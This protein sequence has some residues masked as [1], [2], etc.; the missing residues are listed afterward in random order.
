M[1]ASEAARRE[2][3]WDGGIEEGWGREEVGPTRGTFARGSLPRG[4]FV[5]LCGCTVV[6]RLSALG[7]RLQ[8]RDRNIADLQVWQSL[9]Q[10]RNSF[11]RSPSLERFLEIDGTHGLLVQITLGVGC[12]FVVAR[13]CWSPTARLHKA[14]RHLLRKTNSRNRFEKGCVVFQGTV[15]TV[16]TQEGSLE[17][18]IGR[19]PQADSGEYG[20]D[21]EMLSHVTLR[22]G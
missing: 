22:G 15:H 14:T 13:R 10:V 4:R 21:K 19:R 2:S 1:I 9:K 17:W 11:L 8:T 5:S 18:G 12:P 7:P 6:V 3:A 16:H 20:A